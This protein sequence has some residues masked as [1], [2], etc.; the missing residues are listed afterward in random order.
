MPSSTAKPLPPWP[1]RS[2]H[3]VWAALTGMA[4]GVSGGFGLAGAIPGLPDAFA[5]P[6]LGLAVLLALPLLRRRALAVRPDP[7]TGLADGTVFRAALT[8]TLAE[9]RQDRPPAIITLELDGFAAIRD[10]LGPG[11]GDTLLRQAA[12]RLV[13]TARAED[14]V[15]R[16]GQA[17]FAVL[18]RVGLQP[19]AA[20]RFAGRLVRELSRPYALEGRPLICGAV[21][22][23]AVARAG[24]GVDDLL[25]QSGMALRRARAEGQGT[26]RFFEPGM[27]T[28]LTARHALEG[29]LRQAAAA[30]EFLLHYQPVFDVQTRR[31][32]GFEALLRWSHPDR[33]P[34]SPAEFVPLLEE[35]GLIL[36]VGDWVLRTACREAARWPDP[37]GVAV[38][39]SPVQF[40]RGKVLGAVRAALEESGLAPRR[41]TVEITEGLLLEHTDA[42]LDMLE[43][44]HGLG[45]GIALDDFGSGYSSLAYLWR[46]RFDTLKIDRAF[47][48]EVRRD[49]KAAMIIESIIGLGHS[50]DL[51]ITAEGVETEEQLAALTGVGYDEVQGFL[52]G[53]P[54]PAEQ[55]SALAE[56]SGLAVPKV[57]A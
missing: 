29:A 4:L 6:F 55:A 20:A 24:L 26:A 25:D 30:E 33:G 14:L 42:V 57:A 47:V 45:V 8:T 32:L 43:Q 52:L 49:G 35:T 27:D 22:G 2:A 19:D 53:R 40:R 39:L 17:E 9:A 7:L 46:F 44:L 38:N 11:G 41:L 3:A 31:L 54:M 13:A 21:A 56:G 5:L 15:A 37:I 23:I 48:K 50:L 18:Q 28:A 51:R 16:T 10:T 34:V 36:P 12:A 1:R